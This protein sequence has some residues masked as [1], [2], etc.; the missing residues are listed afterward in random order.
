MLR[1]VGQTFIGLQY[2]IIETLNCDL[3]IHCKVVMFF[4]SSLVILQVIVIVK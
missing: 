3:E 1:R 2:R 4:F